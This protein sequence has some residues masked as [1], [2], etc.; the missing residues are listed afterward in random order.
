MSGRL[1]LAIPSK[2][3][4][5]EQTIEVLARHGLA[6][7]RSGSDRGY[8]GEI[9][10]L[11][12]VEV[13]FMSASEIARHLKSGSI[14]L[15]VTGED[16]VREAMVN[17]DERVRFVRRLGFGEADVV[18]AVPAFWLDVTTL[19]DLGEVAAAYRS[20]HG[21]CLR[22]ATK[23]ASLTRTRFAAAGI[24]DYR[25]IESHGATEGAP[26][27]GT[28]DVVVDITTTGATLRANALRVLDDGVILRSQAC[29]VAAVDAD[30]SP[31]ALQAAAEIARR[32]AA[33]G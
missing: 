32:L 23:Y 31:P 9:T 4:L 7:G 29:L 19:A 25:I 20:R 8:R 30:W 28:A 18:V 26:A 12:G 10:G 3:R 16:L 21:H 22:V 1:V 11:A 13:A 6:I 15:G 5:M 27:A 33:L 14:Q 2:G 17:A 24:L